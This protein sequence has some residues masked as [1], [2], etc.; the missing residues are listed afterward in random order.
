MYSIEDIS[1]LIDLCGTYHIGMSNYDKAFTI[2][3]SES[4]TLKKLNIVQV[5]KEHKGKYTKSKVKLNEAYIPLFELLYRKINDV[6]D[7]ID[8]YDYYEEY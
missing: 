3:K 5:L 1:A 6:K 8:Y 2:Y 7:S 4:L